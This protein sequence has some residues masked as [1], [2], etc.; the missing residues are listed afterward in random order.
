M[1][2][3]RNFINRRRTLDLYGERS[4]CR[5]VIEC[6]FDEYEEAFIEG[7]ASAEDAHFTE[8][9]ALIMM[10]AAKALFLKRG[11][12]AQAEALDL[13]RIYSVSQ[14]A[15][16]AANS[17]LLRNPSLPTL[18][19]AAGEALIDIAVVLDFLRT[20]KR[21]VVTYGQAPEVQIVISEVIPNA[22]AQYVLWHC[23]RKN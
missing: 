12:R 18:E 19:E 13:A 16:A 15:A 3:T 9:L 20:L 7:S 17:I 11:N 21:W 4:D 2:F 22:I 6:A 8:V 14:G 23:A 5:I 10:M 1:N